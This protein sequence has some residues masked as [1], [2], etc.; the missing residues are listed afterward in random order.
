MPSPPER[1]QKFLRFPKQDVSVHF[2]TRSFL[3]F[4][5]LLLQAGEFLG[6]PVINNVIHDPVWPVTALYQVIQ[7]NDDLAV[8][9]A[10]RIVLRHLIHSQTSPLV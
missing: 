7:E 6:M 1:K 4:N 10:L 3:K 8:L 5:V 2:S 9:L